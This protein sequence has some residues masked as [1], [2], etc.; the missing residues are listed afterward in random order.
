MAGTGDGD[1]LLPGRERGGHAAGGQRIAE[2]MRQ[3]PQRGQ[4]HAVLGLREA[5]ERG[6]ALARI[7]WAGD[8]RDAPVQGAGRGEVAGIAVERRDPGNRGGRAAA[9]LEGRRGQ[10][11]A[12]LGIHRTLVGLPPQGD[13]GAEI[14]QFGGVEF[15]FLPAAAITAALLRDTAGDRDQPGGDP[16]QRLLL[17]AAEQAG[18]VAEL[19][20][21][22]FPGLEALDLL[23]PL[24]AGGGLGLAHLAAAA[25]LGGADRIEEGQR[26]LAL[27][28][29]GRSHLAR[30]FGMPVRRQ[31]AGGGALGALRQLGHQRVQRRLGAGAERAVTVAERRIQR[32]QQRFVVRRQIGDGRCG[33]LG[34]GPADPGAAGLVGQ[35]VE[36]GNPGAAAHLAQRDAHRAGIGRQAPFDAADQRGHLPRLDLQAGGEDRGLGRGEA[37]RRALLLRRIR[38]VGGNIIGCGQTWYSPRPPW[39]PRHVTGQT[40]CRMQAVGRSWACLAYGGR[41]PPPAGKRL[42]E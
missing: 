23:P 26:V 34:I 20:E 17:D 25:R 8:Q 31:G 40:G 39:G 33:G 16:A 13:G 19:D 18:D 4:R 28:A 41:Y 42:I 5:V 6:V 10:A 3:Q 14:G 7:G 15:P 35:V 21:A 2:L 30:Q 11:A 24:G 22:L 32:G 29:E 37:A 1:A 36:A 9:Q 38:Q 12:A 27:Q